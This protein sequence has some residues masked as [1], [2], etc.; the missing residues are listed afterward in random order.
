MA[1]ALAGVESVHESNSC[2]TLLWASFEGDIVEYKGCDD[3]GEQAPGPNKIAQAEREVKTLW[4][5]NSV[6]TENRKKTCRVGR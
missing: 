4:K 3:T 6:C 2:G 1:G 5:V